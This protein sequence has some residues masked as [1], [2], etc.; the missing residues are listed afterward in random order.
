MIA[1]A[2]LEL[3]DTFTPRFASIQSILDIQTKQREDQGPC[4]GTGVL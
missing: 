3:K 1:H 4:T 2:A